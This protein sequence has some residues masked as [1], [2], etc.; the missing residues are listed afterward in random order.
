MVLNS[1][2][3]SKSCGA[4][5]LCA[6]LGFVY[7]KGCVFYRL[8]KTEN[9]SKTKELVVAF[10]AGA[11]QP[12]RGDEARAHMGLP[13]VG[14]AAGKLSVADVLSFEEVDAVYIQSTSPNR[15]LSVGQEMAFIEDHKEVPPAKRTRRRGGGR[16]TDDSF[17][18][19]SFDKDDK[20]EEIV[21]H[22]QH[23]ASSSSSSRKRERDLI[24]KDIIFESDELIGFELTASKVER[25]DSLKKRLLLSAVY[26]LEEG[27]RHVGRDE[28]LLSIWRPR[29]TAYTDWYSAL[30]LMTDEVHFKVAE[31]GGAFYPMRNYTGANFFSALGDSVKVAAGQ[32]LFCVLR[33]GGRVVPAGCE[34]VRV[35]ETIDQTRTPA[36]HVRGPL[37]DYEPW[38]RLTEDIFEE[39][40]YSTFVGGVEPLEQLSVVDDKLP[41][42][43]LL[44]IV[45][46]VDADEMR[47]A[48][49]KRIRYV[50]NERTRCDFPQFMGTR[51]DDTLCTEFGAGVA[52]AYVSEPVSPDSTFL[53]FAAFGDSECFAVERPL[54][55][56][57]VATGVYGAHPFLNTVGIHYDNSDG[58]GPFMIRGGHHDNTELDIA[59]DPLLIIKFLAAAV[60]AHGQYSR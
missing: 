52:A 48:S 9:I 28:Q 45:D 24:E 59:R 22:R 23:T 19:S 33:T 54:D 15:K 12:L 8:M 4:K 38:L 35:Q 25:I 41:P 1:V 20:D 49:W 39:R 7:V 18:F 2:A 50:H 55:R 60:E 10:K 31:S 16:E 42:L 32:L 43:A 34:R 44:S 47:A 11:R 14:T 13:K 40:E 3:V 58:S 53:F 36:P 21:P 27:T 26:T 29:R 56:F 17:S 30:A 37:F 51:D 46:A 6:E 5:E 57:A